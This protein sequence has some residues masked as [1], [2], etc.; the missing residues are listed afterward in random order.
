VCQYAKIDETIYKNLKYVSIKSTQANLQKWISCLKKSSKCHQEWN[1]IG[2]ET[3]LKPRKLNTSENYVIFSHF[4]L[5][6]FFKSFVSSY[7]KL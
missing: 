4:I 6:H 2:I 7:Y 3:I 5:F 1:K